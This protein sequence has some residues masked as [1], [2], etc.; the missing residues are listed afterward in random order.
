M[1]L[2][3]IGEQTYLTCVLA[4][5]NIFVLGKDCFLVSFVSRNIDKLCISESVHDEYY[6]HLRNGY[7]LNNS[8]LTVID[9]CFS[10]L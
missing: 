9:D 10:Y 5:A 8:F 7:F 3:C 4:A 2:S 6:F 1:K